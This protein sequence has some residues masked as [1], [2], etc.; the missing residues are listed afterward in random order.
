MY[1]GHFLYGIFERNLMDIFPGF[2]DRVLFQIGIRRNAGSFPVHAQD[3]LRVLAG[4]LFLTAL[5]LFLAARQGF[6]LLFQGF[7]P[8]VLRLFAPFFAALPVQ[9][10]VGPGILVNPSAGRFHT[11]HQRTPR[12]DHTADSGQDEQKNHSPDHPEKVVEHPYERAGQNASSRTFLSAFRI[13]VRCGIN[14]RQRD[15]AGNQGADH[16]DQEKKDNSRRQLQRR[17]PVALV[18]NAESHGNERQ[19]GDSV[20]RQPE[21]AEHYPADRIACH[22]DYSEIAQKQQNGQC[23]D[24]NQHHFAGDSTLFCRF[25]CCTFCFAAAACPLFGTGRSGRLFSASLSR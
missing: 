23:E 11:A 15:A 17:N 5:L 20:G 10:S 21:Y 13:Q 24:P 19:D 25:C 22:A 6:F 7:Q 1:F 4:L 3:P 18:G 9:L 12:K 14:V 2:S 8:T 16:A